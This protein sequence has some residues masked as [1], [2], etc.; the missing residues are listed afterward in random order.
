[1]YRVVFEKKRYGELSVRRAVPLALGLLCI[2]NPN[3][4]VMETLSKLSHD[5]DEE[6]SQ[7]AVLA[8]GLIGAGLFFFFC[9]CVC[10]CKGFPL[11]PHWVYSKRYSRGIPLS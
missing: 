7:N 8:L 6:A 2:S 11:L 4:A 1:M 5:Q 3:L 9:V 10:V